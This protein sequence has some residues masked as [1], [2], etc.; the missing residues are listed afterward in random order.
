MLA[1]ISKYLCQIM[2]SKDTWIFQM[3]TRKGSHPSTSVHSAKIWSTYNA[4][5][6]T[7]GTRDTAVKERKTQLPRVSNPMEGGDTESKEARN[8]FISDKELVWG[9]QRAVLQPVFHLAFHPPALTLE[10]KKIQ[11]CCPQAHS[12]ALTS[13]GTRIRPS[14]DAS[15]RHMKY[16][17]FRI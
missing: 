3:S 4:P 7:S 17:P 6:T 2:F 8:K 9:P 13:E 16:K 11:Q 1:N 14:S 12:G 5:E 15:F 10:E